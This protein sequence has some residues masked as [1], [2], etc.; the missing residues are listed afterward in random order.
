MPHAKPNPMKLD[1]EATKHTKRDHLNTHQLTIAGHLR[2]SA[3]TEI[4]IGFQFRAISH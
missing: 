3:R 1:F 2:Y 4:E